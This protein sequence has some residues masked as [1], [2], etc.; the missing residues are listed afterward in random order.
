[1]SISALDTEFAGFQHFRNWDLNVGGQQEFQ[2]DGQKKAS[3]PL[4]LAL[5]VCATDTVCQ[6]VRGGAGSWIA[7]SYTETWDVYLAYDAKVAP[8][9]IC[10][11][12]SGGANLP[13]QKYLEC[14]NDFGNG[15]NVHV[16]NHYD[17]PPDAL[18]SECLTRKECIGMRVLNNKG[19]GDLLCQSTTEGAGYLKIN[20]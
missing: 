1:L 17:I 12:H 10:D 19:G 11:I 5:D 4:A 15:I 20:Q 13:S 18:H 8:G 14:H 7:N 2:W 9:A 16:L 6:I 3:F